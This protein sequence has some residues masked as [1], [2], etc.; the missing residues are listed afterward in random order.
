LYTPFKVSKSPE[1]KDW[2][3]DQGEKDL[4]CEFC[5]EMKFSPISRT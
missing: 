2:L 3:T 5:E 4:N 1:T